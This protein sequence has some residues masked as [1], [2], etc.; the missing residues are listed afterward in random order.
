VAPEFA[1]P[2]APADATVCSQ[3]VI[4]RLPIDAEWQLHSCHGKARFFF[5]LPN[6]SKY[7][8]H[9]WL[10]AEW[11]NP[12]LQRGPCSEPFGMHIVAGPYGTLPVGV[13][14]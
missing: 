7:G 13:A 12:R 8:V 3:T 2:P 1:A 11:I 5:T 4:T 6:T 9:V 10:A 14:A